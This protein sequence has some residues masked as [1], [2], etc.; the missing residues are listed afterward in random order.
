VEDSLVT[1]FSSR[2]DYQL[3]G[4]DQWNGSHS[5]L[6]AFMSSTG[7]SF[8][9]LL[10]A[11]GVVSTYKSTYDRLVVIDK[12]GKIVFAGTKGAGLDISQVKSLVESLLAE[13]DPMEIPKG[14]APD[15][16]LTSVDGVT[17]SLSDYKSKVRVLFFFGYNCPYCKSAAPSIQYQLVLPFMDRTDFQVLGLDQWNGTNTGVNSFRSSTGVTFPLL[18]NAAATATAYNTTYDRL[19]VIDTSGNIVFR[20]TQG[21][22]A[23]LPAVKEKVQMLLGVEDP[24][25]VKKGDAPDFT[26]ASLDGDSISL[27]DNKN[28]VIVLFFLG[29]ACPFCKAAGPS[30]Q[31]ELSTPYSGRSDYLILGLDQWN[32][33]ASGLN[34]FREST[35]VGFPL[36]LNASETASD[37]ETTYDRLIVIDRSG[38]IVFRGS[39]SAASDLAQ[40]KE[41]VEELL[42]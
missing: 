14:D 28:K 10:N 19:I 37:Y 39:R 13:D 33:T 5:A 20:G 30:I 32:G 38:N 7:V 27:S 26:L 3:L 12:S 24:G 17:V 1:P 16:S 4:L 6:E 18:M 34:S 35:G 11:S 31:S 41:K 23:D 22:A 21:S 40:V 36:L 25:E 29:Y 15:F 8:P 42:P 9:L 2:T